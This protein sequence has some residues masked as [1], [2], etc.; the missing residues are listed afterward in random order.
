M[1]GSLDTNGAM[2]IGQ[3][4][5]LSEFRAVIYNAMAEDT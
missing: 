3:I 1:T 5:I 4:G 2:T